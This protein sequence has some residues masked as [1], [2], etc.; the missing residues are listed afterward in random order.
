MKLSI[1]YQKKKEHVAGC[2]SQGIKVNQL[3]SSAA[4][5]K[6][7]VNGV[8]SGTLNLKNVYTNKYL[9]NKNTH[10]NNDFKLHVVGATKEKSHGKTAQFC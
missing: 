6:T 2:F 7:A 3:T 5:F 8:L 1:R 9:R 4:N 10:R